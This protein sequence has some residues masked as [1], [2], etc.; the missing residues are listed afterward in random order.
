[1]LARKDYNFLEE[2]KQ[3]RESA[4]RLIGGFGRNFGGQG[5]AQLPSWLF[6]LRKAAQ[7]RGIRLYFLPRGMARREQ[8]RSR[9]NH[10]CSGF[11][12]HCLASMIEIPCHQCD[13]L[14]LRCQQVCFAIIAFYWFKRLLIQ[15]SYALFQYLGACQ[16]DK[17]KDVIRLPFNNGIVQ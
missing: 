16:I 2:T 9:H 10:R 12:A 11:A 1:M 5:G 14:L 7:R 8:N 6:F 3:V 15:F 17:R 13:A 4:H